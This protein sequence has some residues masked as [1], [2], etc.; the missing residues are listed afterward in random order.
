MADQKFNISFVIGAVDNVSLKVLKINDNINKAFEPFG[1]LGKSFS[2]LGAE[3][4]VNKLGDALKNVGAKGSNVLTEFN[5]A[6]LR[7][8]AAI[9][10]V[11]AGLNY[12]VRGAA[13]TSEEINNVSQRLGVSRQMFQVLQYAAT[14][15]GVSLNKLEPT[16]TKFSALLG[17]AGEEGNE[18][19]KIFR[20]FGIR[21]KD[22]L[23]EVR[24][25]EQILPELA[26]KFAAIE[27]PS[28]RNAV[29]IKLFG[30]EGVKFAQ[31]LAGGSKG[32][33]DFK[34]RAEE[35][36]LILDDDLLKQGA[37]VNDKFDEMFLVFS[38][39][40]DM[41]GAQFFP[42]I[43]DLMNQLIA[44]FVENRPQ[45]IAFAKAI[46]QDLPNT[47]KTIVDAFKAL[48]AVLQPIIAMFNAVTKVFGTT[49]TIIGI[50]TVAITGKLIFAIYALMGALVKLGIVAA[51]TPIGWI[52]IGI[53]AVIVAIAALIRYWEPLK[54]FFGSM[55]EN[56]SGL[57]R[58]VLLF[59]G[60]L[61]W[62]ASIAITIYKNWEPIAALFTKIGSGISSIAGA[63]PGNP[64]GVGGA[65]GPPAGA[66]GPATGALEA[67]Q[68][69]NTFT[70]NQNE[71]RVVVDFN[72]LPQGTRVKTEKAEAP[73]DLNLGYG[74]AT[75]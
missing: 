45:I 67:V 6:A 74:M 52:A 59:M 9:G 65:A 49:N 33:G 39:L 41:I 71:S 10:V 32:L 30:K 28:V 72:N 43:T 46:A 60:P 34:K 75:G 57:L 66:T 22:S 47:L 50:I 69:Q 54:Q 16:L 14:Q 37:S 13:E 40:R 73:L 36:G 3:L 2:F 15:S 4:G 24:P 61:G 55:F 64:F 38:R 53:T 17:T 21:V 58:I 7:L 70:R 31:I 1:K 42:V 26:D 35:L 62:L 23:G 44:V 68:A 20:T 11:G 63:I 56:W 27:S 51:T 12:F 48:V 25:L 5:S 29:A 8:G 18:V 19:G